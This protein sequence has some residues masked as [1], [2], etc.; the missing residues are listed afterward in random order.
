[1]SSKDIEELSIIKEEKRSLSMTVENLRS[2]LSQLQ[3]K[4]YKN[5][6]FYFELHVAVDIFLFHFFVRAQN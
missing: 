5:F 3:S 4:V 2:E 1:M 6:L